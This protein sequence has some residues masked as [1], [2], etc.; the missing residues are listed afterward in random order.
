MK[1]L[2]ILL[3]EKCKK[4]EEVFHRH[5]IQIY[6]SFYPNHSK[7]D[8]ELLKRKC[9]DVNMLVN[10]KYWIKL[11]N[12]F[13]IKNQL[14][15]T[16]NKDNN[17]L[18]AGKGIIGAEITKENKKKRVNDKEIHIFTKKQKTNNFSPNKNKNFFSELKNT[19]QKH[20]HELSEN[21]ISTK[22]KQMSKTDTIVLGT[23]QQQQHQ[24]QQEN[25]FIGGKE[26]NIAFFFSK[27]CNLQPRQKTQDLKTNEVV[28]TTFG[29]D[30]ENFFQKYES[31]SNC[32]SGEKNTKEKLKYIYDQV[33]VSL[34]RNNLQNVSKLVNSGN[35]EINKYVEEKKIIERKSKSYQ[36]M[37]KKFF[38]RLKGFN[39]TN[40][41]NEE[42]VN[43][44]DRLFQKENATNE[45]SYKEEVISVYKQIY[46]SKNEANKQTYLNKI[47]I[48]LQ[49][50]PSLS[51]LEEALNSVKT[52][53]PPFTFSELAAQE[54]INNDNLSK[55]I[56]EEEFKLKQNEEEEKKS[57]VVVKPSAK[58]A[59]SIEVKE[60][61]RLRSCEDTKRKYWVDKFETAL[62]L[63][64]EY[65][66]D[67]KI[68]LSQEC[69]QNH[70]LFHK[71]L[72][73]T[74]RKIYSDPP[75]K[76]E[77]LF[78]RR[79]QT[80]QI[81]QK[82]YQQGVKKMKM[83]SNKKKLKFQEQEQDEEEH[84]NGEKEA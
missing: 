11:S 7:K 55:H 68:L 77:K 46:N 54:D 65:P 83:K 49:A 34:D 26:K 31:I 37:F 28:S 35:K 1:Y 48:F 75:E 17:V 73:E 44:R 71:T 53:L 69:E 24:Q 27:E 38:C 18:S 25:Q 40:T 64:S 41:P 29:L 10:S 33:L 45:T 52:Q 6:T 4:N 47:P 2:S 58:D 78:K 80:P 43:L 14:N 15:F 13:Q 84:E 16:Q 51:V 67:L 74:F 21:Q 3:S 82:K 57:V 72:I 30:L 36:S 66:E 76:D 39:T 32:S 60:K 81:F 61:K 70:Q 59:E 19:I 12:Q 79:Y 8:E 9:K 50:F 23:K 5:L 56:V 20:A 22:Q 42:F 62:F 63:N